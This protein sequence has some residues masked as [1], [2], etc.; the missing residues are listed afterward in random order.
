MEEFRPFDW[1]DG[2]AFEEVLKMV[3]PVGLC[4]NVVLIMPLPHGSQKQQTLFPSS[5]LPFSICVLTK[6]PAT[7][8]FGSS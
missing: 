3:S 5:F 4:G 1:L 7:L 2:N 6:I 8:S